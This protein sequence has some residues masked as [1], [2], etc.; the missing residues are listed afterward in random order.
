[1][2]ITRRATLAG[3]AALGLANSIG[4]EEA[5]KRVT[6][7]YVTDM[8]CENCAKKLAAKLYVVPGV[9][10][11]KANVAKDVAFVIHQKTKDPQPAALW[12]AVEAAGFEIDKLHT[13]A[14]VLTEK[15]NRSEGHTLGR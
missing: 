13:P 10:Q 6:A 11:V 5:K 15:P 3:L 1:M 8:H 14:A 4:A 2:K 9:V 7:I 12:D